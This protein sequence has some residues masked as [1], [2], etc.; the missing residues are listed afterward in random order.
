MTNNNQNHTTEQL[1]ETIVFGMLEKKAKEI[2]IIDLREIQNA[3]SSYYVICHG[4]SNTQVE[5]IA[6]SAGHEA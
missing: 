4:L 2:T 3:V 1:V 6:E 5:A